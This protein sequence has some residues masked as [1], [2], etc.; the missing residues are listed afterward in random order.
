MAPQHLAHSSLDKIILIPDPGLSNF[1]PWTPTM[2]CPG[3]D[4][5]VTDSIP[6]LLPRGAPFLR[7]TAQMV[8]LLGGCTGAP[9]ESSAAVS[10]SF[11]SHPAWH[12]LVPALTATPGPASRQAPP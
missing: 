2:Q 4:P 10:R 7:L 1:P 5:T 8:L 6:S 11:C 12:S 9:Q 3:L